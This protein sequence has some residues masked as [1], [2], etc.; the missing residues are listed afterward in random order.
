MGGDTFRVM[1]ITR[2]IQPK[3]AC[4]IVAV[5]LPPALD[6]TVLCLVVRTRLYDQAQRLAAMNNCSTGGAVPVLTRRP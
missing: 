6:S 3:P 4:R 5:T 2:A 1:A